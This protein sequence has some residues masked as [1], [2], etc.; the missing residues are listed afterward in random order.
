MSSKI[1]TI[2]IL[3]K[4]IHKTQKQIYSEQKNDPLFDKNQGIEFN[5][6]RLLAND[7]SL[8]LSGSF[9][10]FNSKSN[11]EIAFP[12][13][14]SNPDDPRKMEEF[15]ID[16][17]YRYFLGNTLNGFYLSGFARYAHLKGYLGGTDFGNLFRETLTKKSTENKIG[18]GVGIGYRIFSY[19]GLYWGTSASFG[20]YIIGENNKFHGDFLN[21]DDDGKIIIDFE[22]LKFGIAF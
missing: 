3:Q 2:Y 7:E 6:F 21:L 17:H 19:K 5:I 1:D 4:E 9:S 8:S 18:V 15:T 16:C 11:V 13:F 20:R 10:L 22:L 12:V 14:Y